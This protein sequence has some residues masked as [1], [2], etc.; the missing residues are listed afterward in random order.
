LGALEE[1]H[2]DTYQREHSPWYQKLGKLIG[3]FFSSI[4]DYFTKILP[5]YMERK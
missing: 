5:Q 3:D 4:R 2:Y 1:Y